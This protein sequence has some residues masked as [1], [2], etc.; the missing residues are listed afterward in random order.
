MQQQTRSARQQA[1]AR[2]HGPSSKTLR[3][4]YADSLAPLDSRPLRGR[5][6]LR[7][8]HLSRGNY[9]YGYNKIPKSLATIPLF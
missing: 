4:K 1:A 2:P 5:T 9:F 8:G 6:G 3:P 7:P